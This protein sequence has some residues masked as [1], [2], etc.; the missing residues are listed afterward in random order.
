FS[1]SSTAVWARNWNK[2]LSL[3]EGIDG[4]QEIGSAGQATIIAKVGGTTTAIY[5]AAFVRSPEGEIVYDD[6][7]LPAY[8]GEDSYIGDASPDWSAG[9]SNNFRF[10]NFNLNI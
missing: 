1:W 2:V 4:Q 7:G 9:W 5:G 6:A 8:P 3:A 10:G